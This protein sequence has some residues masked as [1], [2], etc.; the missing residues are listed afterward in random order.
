MKW[1]WKLVVPVIVVAL[2]FL[3]W[4]SRPQAVRAGD[5]APSEQASDSLAR[6]AVRLGA[7]LDTLKRIDSIRSDSLRTALA[8]V[9]VARGQTRRLVAAWKDSV[10]FWRDSAGRAYV[11][12]DVAEGAIE[13]QIAA[14]SIALK[15]CTDK[16]ASCAARAD[17]A[18]R[19][20]ELFRLS[21]DSLAVTVRSLKGS[22]ARAERRRY[23]RDAIFLIVGALAGRASR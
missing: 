9:T 11:P 6:E 15:A 20:A 7:A 17:T 18:E 4:Q 2:L 3:I 14:D 22:V 13:G 5:P 10:A 8:T 1:L 19:R 23:V 21:R 12:V 16:V